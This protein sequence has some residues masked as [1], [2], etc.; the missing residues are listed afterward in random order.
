MKFRTILACLV[1]AGFVATLSAPAVLGQKKDVDP[2]I[3][4]RQKVMKSQVVNL[5]GIFDIV[6]KKVPHTGNLALHARNIN[7]NAKMILAAFKQRVV[8][9]PTDAKPDIWENWQEFEKKAMAL[10]RET[11]KLIE[12][13]GSR[14]KGAFGAQLKKTGKTCGSCHKKFRKPKKESYKR[15]KM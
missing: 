10:Q 12:A 2:N 13:A 14:E 8:E 7:N 5:L 3:A 9:G 1:I 6:K 15:K 4:Y 11:A